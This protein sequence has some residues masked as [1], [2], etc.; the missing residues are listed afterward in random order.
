[1]KKRSVIIAGGTGYIG[2]YVAHEFLA[3]GEEV[4]VLTRE[5]SGVAGQQHVDDVRAR[6]SEAAVVVADVTNRESVATALRGR[7]PK[8]FVSCIASRSGEPRDAWAV[9]YGANR[10][11]LECALELGAEQFVLLSAICVQKP[12]LEFQRAKLRF[13]EELAAA[14]ITHSI[15]RPTA[16]F[17]SLAG[18]IARVRAGRPFLLPGD[19]TVTACK[20]ISERD[21]ARFI[22]ECLSDESRHDAML[23]IGGPGPA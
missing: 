20:P 3:R 7:A 8:A 1:M 6:F 11:L 14:P 5:R 18:Q 19:G 22:A 13:E 4:I 12:A 15:V 23:P 21:L 16:F 9:D 2:Q 10:A 17:K